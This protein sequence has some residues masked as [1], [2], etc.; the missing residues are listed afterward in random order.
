MPP[1][2]SLEDI[3]TGAIPGLPKV[4]VHNPVLAYENGDEFMEAWYQAERGELD[5][6]VLV[7]EGSIPNEEINGEG[8]WAGD[9]HEPVDRPADHDQ[10]VARP[11]GAEGRGGRGAWA[12]APPTAASRP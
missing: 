12:P 6:F 10:R 3:I 5:P 7:L 4:V 9:G 2:P 8:H 1:S 11:P